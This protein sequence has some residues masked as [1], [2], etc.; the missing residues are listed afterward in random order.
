LLNRNHPVKK[1][2]QKILINFKNIKAYCRKNS[3]DFRVFQQIIINEEYKSVINSITKNNID[4]KTIVD[5]GA[6]I[7][8]SSVYLSDFFKDAKL[9]CIEP[10]GGNFSILQENIAL[11]SKENAIC[12]NKGIWPKDSYLKINNNFRDGS[13]WSLTVEEVSNKEESE[14]EAISLDSLMGLYNLEEIS[15]LKIDIEGSERY[16]FKHEELISKILRKTKCIAIEIHDEYGVR[17]EI[18]QI[19]KNNQFTLSHSGELTIGINQT[20]INQ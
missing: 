5:C 15:I 9:Y 17:K 19:L 20:L 16:L 14:V 2:K 13:N 1:V 8:L 4:V 6:N 18:E 7:G 3:S 10:D 11:N 12:I